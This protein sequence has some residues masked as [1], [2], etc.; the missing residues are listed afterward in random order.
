[1]FYADAIGL[2]VVRDTLVQMGIAPA[3]LLLACIDRGMSLSKF[4]R[5]HGAEVRAAGLALL[6]GGK[7]HY[8]RVKKPRAK[9]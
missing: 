4:W 1:M 6:E 2:E 8:S 3:K 9:L 5:T 7:P